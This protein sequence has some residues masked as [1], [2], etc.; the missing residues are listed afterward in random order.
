MLTS[1]QEILKFA[2]LGTRIIL[3][4]YSFGFPDAIFIT[5]KLSLI[6]QILNRYIEP[7]GSGWKPGSL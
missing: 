5:A 2:F 1:Y 4:V 3:E 7:K 6:L